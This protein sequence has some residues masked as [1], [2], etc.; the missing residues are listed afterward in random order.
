MCG[1]R[2]GTAREVCA[3][4][5][6]PIVRPYAGLWRRVCLDRRL[7][8]WWSGHG[9]HGV[10]REARRKAVAAARAKAE[11]YAEAAAITA[12][13]LAPRHIVVSAAVVL[14]Y[15]VAHD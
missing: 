8:R 14:G 2:A 10:R 3:I 9:N 15:A 5:N 7:C 11:L 12:Q 6:N 4:R 1:G 13:D